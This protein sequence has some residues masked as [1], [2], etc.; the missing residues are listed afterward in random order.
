MA[1]LDTVEGEL[2]KMRNSIKRE[3]ATKNRIQNLTILL[4]AIIQM[5]DASEPIPPETNYSSYEEW[6]EDVSDDLK[7]ANSSLTTI[8]EYKELIIALDSYVTGNQV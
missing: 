5:G 4:E 6:I 7:S 1:V 3:G 2:E 8:G